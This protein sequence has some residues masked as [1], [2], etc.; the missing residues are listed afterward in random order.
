MGSSKHIKFYPLV[1]S[2]SLNST[3]LIYSAPIDMRNYDDFGIQAKWTGTPTGNFF[4]D[5]SANYNSG[6]QP[7]LPTTAVPNQVGDWVPSTT[8]IFQAQGS[9]G[10][11]QYPTVPTPG[12]TM[13]D[14]K[15][16]CYPWYRVRFV[17]S[18]ASTSGVLDVWVSAK[19]I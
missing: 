13:I 3:A 7:Q 15:Q 9:S 17:P 19:Q 8:A 6:L 18:S 11:Q 2:C 10:I 16:L 14:M 5:A 12:V 4:L 1:A